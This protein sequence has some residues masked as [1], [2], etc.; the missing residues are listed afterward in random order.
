MQN[1]TFNEK[2][3]IPIHGSMTRP[4]SPQEGLAEM[5][6]G[7]INWN[8]GDLT[9]TVSTDE[10]T[11]QCPTTGQPDFNQ[12]TIE[13]K[14]DK[15]YLESKTIKFYLWSFRSYGAHCESLAQKICDDIVSAINPKSVLV[16]VNQSPR[17]GIRI[18]S[19]AQWSK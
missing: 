9:V 5:T 7:R 6:L 19:K 14:P 11:S 16:T 12:I 4:A 1:I 2:P 18:V 3:R 15:F 8:G 10:F 13:Y 17:G